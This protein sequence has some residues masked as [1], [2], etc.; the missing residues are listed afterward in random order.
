M[1][2]REGLGGGGGRQRRVRGKEGDREGV[3]GGK[4]ERQGRD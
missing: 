4:G 1:D 3:R 2:T